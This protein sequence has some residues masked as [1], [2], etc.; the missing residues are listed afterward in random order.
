MTDHYPAK[1]TLYILR[2]LIGESFK[3]WNI[4]RQ[5]CMTSKW[6]NGWGQE[7]GGGGQWEGGW[8][9][10]HWG[11]E[12]TSPLEFS[13]SV[14]IIPFNLLYWC[15]FGQSVHVWGS[16]QWLQTDGS[17]WGLGVNGGG[18]GGRERLNAES[19]VEWF[20]GRRERVLTHW[21]YAPI[22]KLWLLRPPFFLFFIDI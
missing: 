13:L 7:K 8:V 12:M 5:V 11:R 21:S 3:L 19:I 16:C 22:Y 6:P 18:G 9:S 14:H 15:Q 10:V 2:P 17:S 20:R 1:R 4:M